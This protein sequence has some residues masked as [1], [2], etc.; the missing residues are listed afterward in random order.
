MERCPTCGF[1]PATVAP[2]DAAV[3]ARSLPRRFRA[4][5]EPV[6]DEEVPAEALEHAAQALH[7]VASAAEAVRP[8]APFDRRDL[9]SAATALADGIERLAPDEWDGPRGEA[10]LRGV[11]EGVHHLRAVSRS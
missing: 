1:D 11:H 3:T 8:G 7:A 9:A 6:D 4:A 10:A 5:L 2:S